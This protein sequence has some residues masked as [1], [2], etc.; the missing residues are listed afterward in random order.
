MLI[1]LLLN[2]HREATDMS[3]EETG[4]KHGTQTCFDINI[5]NI[6]LHT[7]VLLKLPARR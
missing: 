6:S 7:C 1:K 5:I 4:L 2:Y 3:T